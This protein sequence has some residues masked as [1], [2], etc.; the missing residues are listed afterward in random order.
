MKISMRW[1]REWV[2]APLADA[3][4]AEQLTLAGLEVE[5]LQAA[6]PPLDGVI[7]ARLVEA[8]PHPAR[9]TLTVCRVDTGAGAHAQVVCGAAGLVPGDCYALAPPGVTLPGG[10]RIETR[11]CHGVQ[12]A[13]MLCSYDEL[14]LAD[15]GGR[16]LPRLQGSAAPGQDVATL[17]GLDD[18]VLDL[19]LTPDRGDCLGL[20]GLAR[21]V[22]ALNALVYQRPQTPAVPAASAERREVCVARRADCPRYLGRVLRGVNAAAPTPAWMVE[23]LRRGGQRSVNVL[24]DITNYVMLELGQPMHAFDL[25][26]LTGPVTVRRARRRDSIQLLNGETLTPAADCLL[27]ADD[28]GPLALAGILGG[29]RAAVTSA[30]RDI[31]LESA[32]FMP[33]SVHGRAWR[34]GL[35][36]GS[37]M[38]FERGVD[39]A[40]QRPAMERATALA[41][42]I[43]GG[44]PGPVI[45]ECAPQRL[46]PRR[47]LRLRQRWLEQTLGVRIPAA[48]VRTYLERL[49]FRVEAAT[50]GWRVTPPGHRYD[51]GLAADLA[52]EVARLYG[53]DR[54][55][56]VAPALPLSLQTLPARAAACPVRRLRRHLLAHGYSEAVT[57]S[58]VDPALN[59]LFC[60]EAA[61]VLANPL[62]EQ[63]AVMRLSLWPG[64]LGVLRY[65]HHRQQQRVRVFE[66]GAVYRPSGE[67]LCLAGVVLGPQWQEQWGADAR[68]A[69]FYDVKRD[70]EAWLPAGSQWLPVAAPG[71]HPGQSAEML[72]DGQRLGLLGQLHPQ[73]ARQLDLPAPWLFEVYPGRLPAPAVLH[74]EPPSRFPSARRDL[75]LVVDESVSA[76]SMIDA[77]NDKCAHLLQKSVIFDVFRGESLGRDR[78]SF[79]IGLIFQKKSSTLTDKDVDAAMAEIQITLKERFGAELRV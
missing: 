32:L 51:V 34:Y 36:T 23:R 3:A 20:A 39:P 38:R 59:R 13:G 44:Q 26:R 79:A 28:A 8:A 5:S 64:L 17:L 54:L 29:E 16:A 70:L 18:H 74:C 25:D 42:E 2:D 6:A 4:L 47:P 35:H 30:T 10:R 7:A 9:A 78:K 48:E 61:P 11:A 55:P 71:L 12:S 21:E 65:N 77:I 62:S 73:V 69:D 22:A 43:C 24:V 63:A 46:P 33:E 57:Y 19:S 41:L 40:L 56:V 66:Q 72:L 67:E 15:G 14:G 53:Y 1:L 75:A 31:F 52:G 45:E 76:Q 58:F 60:A 68:P 50:G 27:I 49:E 37:S